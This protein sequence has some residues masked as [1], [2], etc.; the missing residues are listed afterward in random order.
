VSALAW[1]HKPIWK[2]RK[3]SDRTAH[4][5]NSPFSGRTPDLESGQPTFSQ[6]SRTLVA[7][8]HLKIIQFS[9][10]Q[11]ESAVSQDS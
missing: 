8:G 1:R 5:Q 4:R 6:R 10:R 2:L 9:C 11:K 3:T 7:T